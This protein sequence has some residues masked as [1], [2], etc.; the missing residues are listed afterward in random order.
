VKIHPHFLP[1]SYQSPFATEIIPVAIFGKSLVRPQASNKDFNLNGAV[2]KCGVLFLK[3]GVVGNKGIVSFGRAGALITSTL[4]GAE[5]VLVAEVGIGLSTTEDLHC[6]QLNVNEFATFQ[7][8][9]A[10]GLG[11]VKSGIESHYIP[12]IVKIQ[13]IIYNF[14]CLRFS[15][16]YGDFTLSHH[17]AVAVK[18]FLTVKGFID[19]VKIFR[20][21]EIERC[22]ILAIP[23]VDDAR[24]VIDIIASA[25]TAHSF[26]IQS[27]VNSLIHIRST[28][29]FGGAYLRFPHLIAKL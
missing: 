5:V 27:T 18:S 14:D 28:L 26:S 12:D 2:R 21:N 4:I 3:V 29:S 1:S 19:A 10:G 8:P 22:E 23:I 7:K 24:E 16:N 9:G 13:Q 20:N 25:S 6:H 11:V 15:G 17:F